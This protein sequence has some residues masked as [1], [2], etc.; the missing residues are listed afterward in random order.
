M[1]ALLLPRST[2]RNTSL[3]DRPDVDGSHT[4]RYI[5]SVDQVRL[6]SRVARMY[7]EQEMR[8]SEI[9]SKLHISQPR[10]SRL[11][12]RASENGI[13]RTIVTVP[14]GVHTDL[15]ERLEEK[16]SLVQVVVVDS[17]QPFE[18]VTFA[19]G[20]A[21]AE[22]LSAT[23]LGGDNVGISS[24][25]GSLLKA[26]GAMRP[27]KSRVVD[28]VVQLVGGMG[29][30]RVQMQATRL[31]GQFAAFT[32]ADPVLLPTPGVLGSASAR[33]ALVADPAVS[34]VTREWSS[35]SVALVGIGAIEPSDLAR[36]SGNAF[37][38]A[39]REILRQ[40]GAVGD[41]CFRFYDETGKPIVS[42]FDQRVIGISYDELMRIDRRI[43]VAG[44]TRKLSAIR[45]AL[46]GGWINVL[47]TDLETARALAVD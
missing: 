25:S 18:D 42:D 40:E 46:L 43:G 4:Q 27:Y 2:E 12:K 11:L 16:Y 32:G 22:Y 38:E 37:P 20:N 45:G 21:T 44:S 5:Q 8:Q 14:P 17:D 35:L 15:E 28:R 34:N 24:W 3:A 47:I 23:L 36:E 33:E 6:A 9:A 19:L 31:I 26:V 1:T 30:P 41:I 29:N 7:Y 13:V 39:D 10:V